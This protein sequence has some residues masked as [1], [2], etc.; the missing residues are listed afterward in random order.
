MR[1]APW[2]CIDALTD[3]CAGRR[4]RLA[5]DWPQFRGNARLTGV[6]A[7]PVPATLKVLWTWEAGDVIESSAAIAGGVVYVGVGNGDS[8][9]ARPGDRQAQVEIQDRSD[10]RRVL[11]R[12]R[13][14]LVYIGDLNGIVHAVNAADGKGV[15][16]FKT[17]SEIKSSPVVSGDQ[18]LIGSY[19]QSLYSI[20]AKTGKENV[21]LQDKWSGPLHARS[22]ERFHLRLRL[23]REVSGDPRQ[24]RQRGVSGEYRVVHRRIARAG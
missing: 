1:R 5:Q 17:F 15:W 10:D 12:G 13:G 24:R 23:R 8:R 16:K 22:D 9:G 20:N 6:T 21:G 2:S 11:A 14:G 18:V 19:D 4:G 7:A 3:S